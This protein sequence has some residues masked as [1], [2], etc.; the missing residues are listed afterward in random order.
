[1]NKLLQLYPKLSDPVLGRIKFE[2]SYVA[3]YKEDLRL[4]VKG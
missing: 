4:G 1:M 3:K 2:L